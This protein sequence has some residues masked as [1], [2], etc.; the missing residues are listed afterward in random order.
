MPITWRVNHGGLYSG[1]SFITPYNQ[2]GNPQASNINRMKLIISFP[3]DFNC[4]ITLNTPLKFQDSVLLNAYSCGSSFSSV[5]QYTTA[6]YIGWN[7]LAPPPRHSNTV[8]STT[9]A[10]W[11][12]DC[13]PG[14]CPRESVPSMAQQDNS[15]QSINILY[16]ESLLSINSP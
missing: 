16:R 10:T 8:L 5:I 3:C 2:L 12:C 14:H 4:G 9:V 1:L 11:H 7:F 6:G 13:I 15:L